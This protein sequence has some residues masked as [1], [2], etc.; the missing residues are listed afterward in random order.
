[1]DKIILAINGTG[2]LSL[3]SILLALL[4]IVFVVITI[5]QN[6]KM[7]EASTRPYIVIYGRLANMQN[8]TYY[9]I[10]KNFGKTGAIIDKFLASENLANYSYRSDMVPFSDI[11]GYF[12]A[13]GQA[14]LCNIEVP[15]QDDEAETFISFDITYS[16]NKKTYKETY[17]FDIAAEATNV[18]VRANTKDAELKIISYTLQDMVEKLL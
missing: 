8:P 14:A 3:V 5:N 18:V 13:P 11:E 7:I 15:K 4:S 1:M 17:S 2:F 16:A 10:I 6:R 12:F 9:L